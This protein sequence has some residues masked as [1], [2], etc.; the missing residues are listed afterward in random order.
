VYRRG[1]AGSIPVLATSKIPLHNRFLSFKYP[2]GA[3][4]DRAL[5][6]GNKGCETRFV[7]CGIN[8]D[9]TYEKVNDDFRSDGSNEFMY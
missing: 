1:R 5:G 4:G 8:K 7:Y 3:R 2:F 6:G 9:K